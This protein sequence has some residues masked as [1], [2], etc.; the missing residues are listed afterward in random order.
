MVV[1]VI[2][3]CL[4]NYALLSKQDA[5]NFIPPC[6]QHGVTGVQIS[7]IYYLFIYLFYLSIFSTYLYLCGR[8]KYFK[9]IANIPYY[10]RSSIIILCYLCT[11]FYFYIN[12]TIKNLEFTA[13]ESSHFLIIYSYIATYL[14]RISYEFTCILSVNNNPYRKQNFL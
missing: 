2:T 4:V 7:A 12:L 5:N 3:L 8:I 11:D 13:F 10:I 9:L 6:I 14:P 1:L